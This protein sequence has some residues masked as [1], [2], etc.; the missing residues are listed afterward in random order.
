M[1][2]DSTIPPGTVRGIDPRALLAH[3]Q[4]STHPAVALR[5]W[6]PP[7]AE[8]LQAHFPQLEIIA[9]LGR[10]GMGAVYRARQPELD[11]FVALKLLP[12][13]ASED[14]AFAER[15]RTEARA[16]ARLQHPHLGT[17]H[18]FGRTETGL[19]FFVMEYVE[20][21]D[22]AQLLRSGALPAPRAVEIASQVADALTAAH[23]QGIVHRDIKPANILLTADGRAKVADFGLSTLLATSDEARLTSTGTF[24]GT[25]DYLA[26]EQRTGKTVDARADFYSLGVLFYEM[27]TGRLPQGAWSPPSQLVPV[28][29]RFDLVVRRALDPE[30]ARRF[31][32]ASAFHQALAWPV[33]VR[34]RRKAIAAIAV[35]AAALGS[36][37][38][39]FTRRDESGPRSLLKNL[40][41]DAAFVSGDWRWLDGRRHEVLELPYDERPPAK[42]LRLP[43]KPGVGSYDL[44]LDLLLTGERS[45]FGVLLKTGATRAGALLNHFGFCGLGLVGGRFWNENETST[46]RLLP[47]GEWQHLNIAVRPQAERV[48]IVVRA[49]NQALLRWTGPQSALSVYENPPGGWAIG[50]TESLAFASAHGGLQIRDVQFMPLE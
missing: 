31:S 36:G 3:A 15:F 13:I 12:E 8:E 41:L 38:W 2:D 9:L 14:V 46:N 20:G 4:A 16:L 21:G 6:Q 11:R 42:L 17:I 37:A 33:P 44:A 18:D 39:W 47:V 22:L 23:A 43:V 49:A 32:D 24:V 28:D 19:W 30:P 27:L 34:S 50:D 40:D 26:P 35:G 25:P 1:K 45:N 29:A 10:G 7:T 5:F 48:S